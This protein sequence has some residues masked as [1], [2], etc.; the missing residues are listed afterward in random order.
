V[1]GAPQAG[2]VSVGSDYVLFGDASGRLVK[3]GYVNGILATTL[4]AQTPIAAGS[5]TQETT[6]LIGASEHVYSVASNGTLVVSATSTLALEWRAD[7]Y[8][9]ISGNKVGQP[10][11][12]VLRTASGQHDCRGIGVLYV[13]TASAGNATLTALLVDSEGLDG[14]APWPKFQRDN[15]NSGNISRSLTSWTCP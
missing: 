6:P 3:V 9:P 11:L 15:A 12:D 4:S 2:P 1:I 10:A 7:N 5:S 13:S 8:F 14:M